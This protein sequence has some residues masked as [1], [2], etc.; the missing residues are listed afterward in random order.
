MKEYKERDTMKLKKTLRIISLFM[1][2]IAVIFVTCALSNPAL[3]SVFYIGSIKITAAINR[4][5]YMLYTIVMILLYITSF[6]LKK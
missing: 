5:F 1:F 6:F 2:I 3:G 4:S